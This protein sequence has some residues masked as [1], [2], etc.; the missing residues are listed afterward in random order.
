MGKK[1]YHVDLTAQE[2]EFLAQIVKRRKSASEAVKRSQVLLAC[3]RNG[4]KRWPDKAISDHYSV[5]VR[6]VERLREKFVLHGLGTALEG[7]PRPNRDKI[8][9]DGAV[10][11]RLVG[12]R[13]SGP[14]AGRSSWTLAL[15]AGELVRLEV[16]E[17]ISRESVRAILKKH[18]QALAGQGMG[19]PGGGRRICLRHGRGPGRVREGLRRTKPGGVL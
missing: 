9:F 8:K 13:C 15:L 5:S 7:M 2:Q 18:D 6:T 17:S 11:A 14:P 10:E 4:D 3:D 19:H 12:L 1:T 16:V